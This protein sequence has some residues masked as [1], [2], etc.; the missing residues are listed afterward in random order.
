[1]LNVIHD[2]VCRSKANEVLGKFLVQAPE[3]INLET[4]V[5]L[6]GKLR[7]EYGDLDTAEGRLTASTHGG[8]IRVKSSISNEGRRRFIIAHELGHFCLHKAKSAYDIAEDFRTW[9]EGS[10]ETEANVF[11]GELLLPERLLTPLLPT[12]PPSL[13]AIDSLADKFRTSNLATGV[14]YVTYI[15][16]PCALIVSK[17][18]SVSWVRKSK[19]FEYFIPRGQKVPSCSAAGEILSGKSADTNGM[20]KTPAWVWLPDIHK[21]SRAMIMEDSRHIEA[22]QMVMTLLWI[23]EDLDD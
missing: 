14:Q 15:M 18:D 5:W 9:D 20:V 1:M 19:G 8:M 17:G 22:Y 7:I 23:D 12:L 2:G 6:T 21:N 16:E 13:K 11:A 4:I 3:E 10:K